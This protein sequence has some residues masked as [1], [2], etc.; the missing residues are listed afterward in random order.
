MNVVQQWQKRWEDL[1]QPRKIKVLRLVA[2][3][4]YFLALLFFVIY[5][6]GGIRMQVR[7]PARVVLFMESTPG[8]LLALRHLAKRSDVSIAMIVLTVNTWSFNLNAAYDNTVAFLTL[9]KEESLLKYHIPVYY[10]SSLAQVNAGFDDEIDFSVDGGKAPNTTACTYRRVLMPSLVLEADTLF[11][12][13]ELLESVPLSA[14]TSSHDKSDGISGQ[15]EFFDVALSN[16]LSNHTAA[17]LVLGPL[18]DAADFLQR[19]LDLRANVNRIFFAGGTL[20]AEGN[21][22]LVYPPNQRSEKHAFFDPLAAN[23]IVSGAHGRPMVL[24]PLDAF[25][26][27]PGTS[28]HHHAG[29]RG[30]HLSSSSAVSISGEVLVRAIVGYGERFGTEKLWPIEM[31]AAL[32]FAD[33]VIQNGATVADMALLV[34]NGFSMSVDG[35]IG[36]PNSGQQ[37]Q[38]RFKVRVVLHLNEETFWSR[39]EAVDSMGV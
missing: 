21:T 5:A 39:V 11:G 34:A 26:E 37:Q 23:Y 6:F 22:R 7:D 4:C 20:K 27:F 2:F 28:Y 36:A 12:A 16:Y 38:N 10:G 35:R 1:P 17:F 13:S 8:A 3:G 33:V 24:L 30:Q 19:H 31:V 9:L 29:S 14:P 32:Y 15:Y 25:P 18:T